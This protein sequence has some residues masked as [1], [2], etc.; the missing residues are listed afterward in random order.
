MPRKRE[1]RQYTERPSVLKNEYFE[2]SAGARSLT[3]LEF[4][5]LINLISLLLNRSLELL[6]KLSSGV[7]TQQ[8]NRFLFNIELGLPR[9]SRLGFLWSLGSYCSFHED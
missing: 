6:P 9:L 1:F 4:Q 2:M 3:W 5:V 8:A 7:P